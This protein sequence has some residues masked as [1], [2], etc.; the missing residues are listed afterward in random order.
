VMLLG[1]RR[2]EERSIDS[3]ASRKLISHQGRDRLGEDQGAR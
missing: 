1:G 3:C 2:F